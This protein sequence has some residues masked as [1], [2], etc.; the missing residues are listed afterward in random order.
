MQAQLMIALYR[1]Q[2]RRLLTEINYLNISF[3]FEVSTYPPAVYY[4]PTAIGNVNR[5]YTFCKVVGLATLVLCCLAC[6]MVGK[7]VHH[8]IQTINFIGVLFITQG[9]ALDGYTDWTQYII[10][11]LGQA[12][13]LGGFTAVACSS[14]T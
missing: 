14:C 4:Q 2:S 10:N 7:S 3:P 13:L 8:A 12:S 11:G 6:L 1:K 9:Y 5:L